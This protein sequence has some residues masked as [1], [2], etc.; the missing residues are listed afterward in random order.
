M[1]GEKAVKQD[2]KEKKPEAKKADAS[3]TVKKGD[4]N[5]KKPKKGK[6]HCSQNPVSADTPG[7]SQALQP[8]CHLPSRPSKFHGSP[9]SCDSPKHS[10]TCPVPPAPSSP[11][12]GT[13]FPTGSLE[14][15]QVET[16]L[17]MQGQR[18]CLPLSLAA[19]L[20]LPNARML[21]KGPPG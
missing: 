12:S 6:P 2:P 21:A 14:H 8:I 7:E 19:V 20:P 11:N 13:F 16:S 1:A 17:R 3:G 15:E 10:H 18:F 4:P 9:Q 5:A